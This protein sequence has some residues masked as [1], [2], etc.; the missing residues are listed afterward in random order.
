ML[1]TCLPNGTHHGWGVAGSEINKALAPLADGWLV[2]FPAE[3]VTDQFGQ[4][5]PLYS[6]IQA[7]LPLAVDSPLIQAVQGENLLPIRLNLWSSVRNVGY[8]FAENQERIRDFAANGRRYFEHIVAGSSWLERVLRDAGL[9]NVSTAIQGV[10]TDVFHPMERTRWRDSFVV[11]SGGKFEYRKGQDIVIRAVAILM[12][13]HA[14]VMLLPLW[15]NP[16]TPTMESMWASGHIKRPPST[17]YGCCA[18]IIHATLAANGIPLERV[19]PVAQP[20][21]HGPAVAELMANCDVGCFPNRAEAGTNLVLMEAMACGLPCVAS[22]G[23]GHADVVDPK[24][25]FSLTIYT[26]RQIYCNDQH[27]ASWPEPLLD[28]VVQS[29]EFAYANRDIARACGAENHKR[30]QQFTWKATARKIYEVM[31]SGGR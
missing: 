3:G 28:E 30:M 26:E 21:P 6:R 13:K 22:T 19:I 18:D 4:T 5:S 12:E 29:L 8:L 23:T 10:D 31:A 1:A 9:H 14:D 15:H 24:D 25:P 27:V 20:V 16:W 2:P 7:G 11:F 17:Y